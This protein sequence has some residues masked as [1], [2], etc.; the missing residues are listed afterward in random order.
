MI[1]FIQTHAEAIQNYHQPAIPWAFR[2]DGLL[3]LN[4]QYA[5]DRGALEGI[6]LA[7]MT[8]HDVVN[9]YNQDLYRGFMATM[10]WGNKNSGFHKIVDANRNMIIEKLERIKAY[11]TRGDIRNAFLSMC[12]GGVNHIDQVD[13]A[14]FTKLFYFMSKAFSP[15]NMPQPLILDRH[16]KFVH[17]ALLLDEYH[18]GHLLYR[19]SERNGLYWYHSTN[20]CAAGVYMDY[21]ERMCNVANS[22]TVAPETL[23]EFLFSVQPANPDSFVYQEVVNQNNLI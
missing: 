18:N 8:R 9:Y 11:V 17:C 23:E 6:D 2:Q 16:M 19:W 20:Q 13:Y 22:I 4:V 7:P 21:I 12:R 3:K 10:L 14:F 1:E 5:Q 15:Q